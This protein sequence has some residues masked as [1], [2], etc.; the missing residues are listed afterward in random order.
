L[1]QINALA[2]GLGWTVPGG[3]ADAARVAEFCARQCEGRT[4]PRDARDA[5]KI[6]EGL[7]AMARRVAAPAGLR[8]ET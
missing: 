1:Q 3:R 2:V 6:I 8:L 5:G 7:K 4:A